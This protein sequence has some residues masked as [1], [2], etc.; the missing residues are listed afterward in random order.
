MP[1]LLPKN[2]QLEETWLE[3]VKQLTPGAALYLEVYDKKEQTRRMATFRYLLTK[4]AR[5]E[6]VLASRIKVDRSFKDRRIWV[7]LKLLI[8]SPLDGFVKNPD[9]T[10]TKVSVTIDPDRRRKLKLM[11]QDGL[12][13]DDINAAL[14]YPMTPTEY[15]EFVEKGRFT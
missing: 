2:N 3:M 5:D 4:L 9:G 14:E 8:D 12:S 15:R 6:P 7:E 10:V 13:I 1:K 11:V